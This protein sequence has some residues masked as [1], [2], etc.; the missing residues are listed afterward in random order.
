MQNP[1]ANTKTPL[2]ADG[3]VDALTGKLRLY[4]ELL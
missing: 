2:G 1:G 3:N 4:K